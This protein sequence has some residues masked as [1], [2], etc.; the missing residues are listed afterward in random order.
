M[1]P[2]I[3]S[4]YGGIKHLYKTGERKKHKKGYSIS[5]TSQKTGYYTAH[6]EIHG[7]SDDKQK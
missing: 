6:G 5:R 2:K 4:T 1:E 3:N 7:P